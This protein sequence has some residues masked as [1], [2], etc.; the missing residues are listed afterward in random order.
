VL[1]GMGE[2]MNISMYNVGPVYRWMHGTNRPRQ[3]W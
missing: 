2:I 3:Q 1:I